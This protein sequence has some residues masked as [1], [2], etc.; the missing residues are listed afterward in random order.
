MERQSERLTDYPDV[1]AQMKV[2]LWETEG[3]LKR[4]DECL[5][6]LGETA[7]PSR[8][9]R[10]PYGKHDGDGTFGCAGDEILKNTFA[11]NAFEN[12]AIAAYE[13]LLV[14]CGPAG[15]GTPRSRSWSNP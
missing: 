10:S 8:I 7:R 1:Q 14:L 3:Q 11:N 12:F 4:L 6:S 2:H 13:S 15:A 9:P 5:S